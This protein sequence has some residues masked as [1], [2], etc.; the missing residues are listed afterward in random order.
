MP[1]SGFSLRTRAEKLGHAAMAAKGDDAKMQKVL[2]QADSM[3]AGIKDSIIAG[4]TTTSPNGESLQHVDPP[5][6]SGDYPKKLR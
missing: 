2:S 6:R 5:N 1:E 4:Q 3:R